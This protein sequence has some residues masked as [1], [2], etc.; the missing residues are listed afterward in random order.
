VSDETSDTTAGG[1]LRDLWRQF[2]KPLVDSLDSR[3]QGEVDRRVDERVDHVLADRVAMLERA[4]AD[5]DRAVKDLT[6]R[7]DA[8]T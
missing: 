3:L 2:A 7:L 4:L 5:L 6:A 8:T 1:D